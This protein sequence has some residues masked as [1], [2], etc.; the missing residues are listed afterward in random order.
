VNLLD[1]M[2]E[3]DDDIYLAVGVYGNAD[4]GALQH[5][6]QVPAS[7]NSNGTLD[8]GEYV[9]VSLKLLRADFDR[10]GTLDADDIDRLFL[11][12]SSTPDA[13]GYD[14]TR[15]G[16]IA[17]DDVQRWLSI[18][19][20][21]YG[22]TN[23]DGD[24]DFGD[25]IT[26]RV[27]YTGSRPPGSAPMSWAQGNSD[28]DG[29]ID[30][31]DAVTLRLNFTGSGDAASD[32][33]M[34]ASSSP[35]DVV[36]EI[37]VNTGQ[38]AIVGSG[39]L[40]GVSLHSMSGLLIPGEGDA[41]AEALNFG[42]EASAFA[43]AALAM[44]TLQVEGRVVLPVAVWLAGPGDVVW[45]Y[46]AAGSDAAVRGDVRYVPEPVGMVGLLAAGAWTAA[47]RRR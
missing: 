41:A 37:D 16:S 46:A 21:T 38:V 5:G 9:M 3:T 8:A 14:M 26:L 25:A 6:Q 13:F 15:N 28:G 29:D 42:L 1:L 27:N 34:D 20:T 43:W 30:F 44:E 47:R 23:L 22:D 32:G 36:L 18:A 24:V 39:S 4:G 17:S 35:T 40:V 11:R 12:H 7:L 19:D 2:G 33:A 31:D 45:R 10:D